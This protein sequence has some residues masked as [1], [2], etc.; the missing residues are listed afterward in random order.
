[1][2]RK[3]TFD[4]VVQFRMTAEMH[5]ELKEEARSQGVSMAELIRLAIGYFLYHEE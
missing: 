1:M 4:A 3:K 2:A 5:W